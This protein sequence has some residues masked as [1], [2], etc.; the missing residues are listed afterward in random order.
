M[1]EYRFDTGET[2][3]ND[4]LSHLNEHSEPIIGVPEKESCFFYA[5]ENENLVGAI[6]VYF[7][8]D[9]VI[10]LD[11]FYDDNEVLGDMLGC[12]AVRY[13]KKVNG[14]H[15]R[16]YEE[17]KLYDFIELGFKH[18]GEIKSRTNHSNLHFIDQTD[19]LIRQNSFYKV[20]PQVERNDNYQKVL[21]QKTK[22]SQDNIK[23]PKILDEITIVALD[24]GEFAGGLVGK[25]NENS[26]H[27]DLLVVPLK[28]R[29]KKIAYH[30]M[31]LAENEARKRGIP[32]MDLST[33]E[34]Q[35]KEFYEKL[36]YKVVY[37]RQNYPSRLEN[38]KMIKEIQ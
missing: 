28:F 2:Y 25:L 20:I 8:W 32:T 5:F 23:I 14:I 6:N 34:F 1:I 29:G 9:W 38:Y 33:G 12:I 30:M 27:I 13:G 37:T 18:T 26:L 10:I 36:G 11:L 4:I 3:I 17:K 31:C 35:A 16:T 21:E 7:N 22:E 15:F 19:I 24:N